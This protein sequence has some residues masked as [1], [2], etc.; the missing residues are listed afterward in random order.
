MDLKSRSVRLPVGGMHCAACS[1]R[2][3]K[4][5]GSLAGVESVSVNLATGEMDLR[6]DP[7]ESSLDQILERVRELGFSVEAPAER[8]VLEL[9]IGGM[10]CAACSSRIERVTG[11]MEGVAE[12]SVNLGAESGRFVFDPSL[13]SQRALRQAI[14][15]AGFSTSIPRKERAGDEEERINAR[16]AEKKKVVIWSMAFALP[17]LVLSMGHMW[18]MPLP[19]WLDPMHAPGTFALAQLLLTLPVVWSGR[20]FYLIGFPALARRAPN[21]DSLVAVGTGAALVYSLWNTVEIWLGV[22]AQARAMDLY[23]E[24]AAVLIAMISLGKFFEARSVSKTT[25]AVR[26]LMALA[27]DTATLVDGG[28][29]REIP[30]EEIEPGD[31]LRIRPGERLPVD[32]EVAEGESHVDESM[33]TGEPLPV[34]RSPGDRVFGGTLNTTGAFVM[35][36]SLVGEDTMLARIVRLVRDAQGSKAPIAS[37]ADTVSYYFVPVVMVLAVVSGLAWY[38]FSDEPFVFALRTAISVL[39]IACPCAMGLATPTSIMVGTGRGAQLGVLI[40]SG[41]ALQRAG[42]LQTLVFDKTGTLTVGKPVLN[43]VWIAPGAKIDKESLLRLS[44]SIES[45]SEHP[46]AR[47]VVQAVQAPLP[48]A[49]EFLS[50][51][52]QGVTAV[53][54]ERAVAI[55]NERLMRA[56]NLNLEEAKAERGRMEE[57]GATVVHVAVDGRL[58]GLLAVSDR[59]RPESAG[60]VRRL[61]D[62]GMEI[63]LLTGDSERAARAVA[64]KLGIERVVAGVLPDRKAE[65]IVRLQENDRVVGMVGDGINDA[66]ALAK[67]DLGMA[68]GGGMDVAME[69]GDVVLMREDLTGVLTALA[70]SR[71]VMR[72]IRQNL[73]WA[74]AFNTIGIPIAAGIPHIFGGP[75]MSPMLAGTAMA[76]SSVFVVS[77][78]LRLRF[79]V[80][81]RA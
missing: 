57:N 67:A 53:V 44:A 56:Q 76:M 29:E 15:D 25:G 9:K 37:L 59:L 74:F 54:E 28:D 11:R 8:S 65:E 32:G 7:Q 72:N 3:E 36:A 61:R 38:F 69:S 68:M 78:A 46:L 80:P 64:A 30:V 62:L 55:G 21:M 60:A 41:R 13:V 19:Y 26:A 47:A 33:L 1:A 14:H 75:A 5:V 34:R 63:V 18:G 39:V 50:V 43:E 23:Y 4:V 51:P 12:A 2:I 81:P 40:K 79:F 52:G 31:L 71:A 17:L 73:F 58:A 42:E 70:L 22:D 20:G 27:P 24:S 6:F 49:R 35:R 16:L 10:H 77:N 48:K 45:Q 66:P